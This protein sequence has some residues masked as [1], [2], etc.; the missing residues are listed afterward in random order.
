MLFHCNTNK[1]SNYGN[2]NIKHDYTFKK[3][4]RRYQKISQMTDHDHL[5][6][7][8]II[9]RTFTFYIIY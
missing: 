7:G 8:T 1:D 9:R 3:K 2:N 5:Q 6:N 4:K